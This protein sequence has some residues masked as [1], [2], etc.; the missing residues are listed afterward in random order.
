[1]PRKR[2]L[3]PGPT[4]VPE[5]ALQALG[6]QV[7]HHRTPEARQQ[8]QLALEGLKEVFQTKNDVILFTSSGSGAMEAAV[9]NTIPRGGKAIVLEGGRFSQ[10]W[11]EICVAYGIEVVK[12][13][14]PWGEGIN[15]DEV[16]SLLEKHPDAVA[17]FSTLVETSTGVAHDVQAIGQVIAPTKA[18]FIVDGIS[19]AACQECRVDE[20]GVD[21]FVVG[22]QK[23]LM[24]PPGLAFV[25]VSEKAWKQ[26]ATVKPQA[27]YFNL[28]QCRKKLADPDTP[29]TP[30]HTLIA[31]LVETLKLIRAE[32]MEKVWAR[33]KLLGRA[34][35][36][37]IEAMGLEVFSQRPSDAVTAVKIPAGLDEKAFMSKMEK[38]YGC[39]MAGGQAQLKGKIFRVAHMGIVDELDIIGV[40][41]AIEISLHEL[42]R[43]VE[44]GSAVRAATQVFA[45]AQAVPA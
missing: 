36:A 19:G 38:K 26:I 42:G 21:L 15:P 33:A 20:W 25:S 44:L 5:E 18:L 8:L 39:K 3:T 35:R 27:F 34:C 24:L 11:S 32:G 41:F 2:L 40:L 43:P 23:A 22:S 29:F 17:V 28:T 30:A 1:M 13:E 14:T 4:M 12:H 37:G 7:G 9:T 6:K 10:R 16:A 45:E 31:A